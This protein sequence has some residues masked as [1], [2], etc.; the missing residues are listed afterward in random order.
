MSVNSIFLQPSHC[1]DGADGVMAMLVGGTEM[2]NSFSLV[3][4]N[5][6]LRKLESWNPNLSLKQ[7]GFITKKFLS[8]FSEKFF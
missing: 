4:Y 5:Y 7:N 1:S 6:F 3:I 8:Y 2:V